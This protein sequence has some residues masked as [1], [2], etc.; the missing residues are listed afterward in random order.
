[1]ID[2]GDPLHAADTAFLRAAP[3]DVFACLRDP[4]AYPAWWRGLRTLDH[5]VTGGGVVVGDSWRVRALLGW[6]GVD[7]EVAVTDLR[8][9]M[10]SHNMWMD[11][12]GERDLVFGLPFPRAPFEAEA[13]WYVRPWRLG[14]LLSAFWRVRSEPARRQARLLVHLRTLGWRCMAGLKTELETEAS[15]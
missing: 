2:L 3:A 1:M 11:W 4:F 5:K 6:G 13:E 10:H 8:S 7:A 14:T 15:R 9:S 12:R